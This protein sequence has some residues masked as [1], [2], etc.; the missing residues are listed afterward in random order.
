MM[1]EAIERHM[2]VIK[3][4]GYASVAFVAFSLFIILGVA[5][6]S[7]KNEIKRYSLTNNVS[8][9]AAKRKERLKVALKLLAAK[10]A[11]KSVLTKFFSEGIHGSILS[12]FRD[13]SNRLDLVGDVTFE[14]TVKEQNRLGKVRVIDI[15]RGFKRGRKCIVSVFESLVLPQTVP[16]TSSAVFRICANRGESSLKCAASSAGNMTSWVIVKDLAWDMRPGLS[17]TMVRKHVLAQWRPI[18]ACAKSLIRTNTVKTHG[19]IKYLF[20][21][22]R[23]GKVEKVQLLSDNLKSSVVE[24]CVR[25][26]IRL[27]RFPKS[28]NTTTVMYPFFF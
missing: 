14:Y 13:S 5:C 17:I 3:I 10:S 4:L 16:V 15:S 19:T 12:C 8:S 22:G 18:V 11:L 7:S 1:N 2:Y 28:S 26:C 9:G 20:K 27:W 23:D 6:N 25:S 24:L 21:I